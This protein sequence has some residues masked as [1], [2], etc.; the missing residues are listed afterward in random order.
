LRRWSPEEARWLE[1]VT[2]LRRCGLRRRRSRRRRR[3]NE[4]EEETDGLIF[5]M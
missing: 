5:H 4:K 3:E 2:R 1:V